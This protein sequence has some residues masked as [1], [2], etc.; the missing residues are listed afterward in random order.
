MHPVERF[1]ELRRWRRCGEVSGP[2][3]P[4]RDALLRAIHLDDQGAARPALASHSAWPRGGRWREP[5]VRVGGAVGA[6]GGR[7]GARKEGGPRGRGAA[8][9]RRPVLARAAL[10]AR[11][12]LLSAARALV[13]PRARR[14]RRAARRADRL[15]G[16][17][18]LRAAHQGVPPRDQSAASPSVARVDALVHA[19]PRR[20]E[21]RPSEGLR[22]H[23]PRQGLAANAPPIASLAQ[24]ALGRARRRRRRRRGQLRLGHQ[25]GIRRGDRRA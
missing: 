7:D 21:Q 23:P 16:R 12:L 10:E 5:S 2:A 6:R 18:R 3:R 8:R 1:G 4:Q 22:S 25:R 24:A 11:S 14:M 9:A 17:A 13:R 19:R 20:G 15:E